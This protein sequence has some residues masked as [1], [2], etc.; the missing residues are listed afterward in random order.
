[1]CLQ[2]VQSLLLGSLSLQKISAS[3]LDQEGRT[4]SLRNMLWL[5][6]ARRCESQRSFHSMLQ[7]SVFA[8]AFRVPWPCLR[9]IIVAST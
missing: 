9:D 8:K 1:M 4:L 2:Y 6:E 5:V 3:L 7:Q